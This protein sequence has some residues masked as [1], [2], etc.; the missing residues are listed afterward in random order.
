MATGTQ[1]PTRDAIMELVDKLPEEICEDL[2]SY[3]LD[4][5]LYYDPEVNARIKLGL[6]ELARGDTVTLEQLEAEIG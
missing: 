5:D 1:K 6:A 4:I 2:L 3:L